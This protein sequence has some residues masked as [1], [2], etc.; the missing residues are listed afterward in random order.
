M[1][2]VAIL[3]YNNFNNTINCLSSV[4]EFYRQEEIIV[5]LVDNGS[6]NKSI[7]SICKYLTSNLI[8]FTELNSDEINN[9]VDNN[10]VILKSKLNV[11]YA[12]GNNFA[13]KFLLNQNVNFIQILNNDILLNKNILKPLIDCLNT[14]PDIGMISPLLLDEK[15]NIDYN[16]CRKNPSDLNFI[17][18]SLR[19][20]NFSIINKLA[21]N[22][23]Y[24]SKNIKS[25]IQIIKCDLISGACILAK[26]DLW[27]KID[28][29]DPN[30]FLYYEENIL[31]EKLRKLNLTMAI[32]KTVEAIHLGGKSTNNI[33][34]TR[35]LKIE[36]S[37]L[38]YYL[39]NYRNMPPFLLLIIKIIRSFQILLLSFFNLITSSRR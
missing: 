23:Y 7:S 17:L 28:G 25:K 36:Y 14:N 39:T 12:Q 29:F 10:V 24:Y 3:N 13:I 6:N 26:A 19:F 34:N 1:V 33:L 4:L 16:C 15:N 27:R 30:T 2:G 11:G 32:L 31:F 18:Q 37:S 22:K 38:I 35:L 20:L 5:A 21:A 9:K 8:E